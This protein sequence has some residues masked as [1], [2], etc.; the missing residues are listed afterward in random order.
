MELLTKSG[1][2]LMS[3]LLTLRD[4]QKTIFM[5]T[6]DIFRAKEYADRVG[7]LNNGELLTIIDKSE[8][9]EQDL[10]KTYL[11]FMK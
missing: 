5:S 8:L 9:K 6:H 10:E 11:N 4:K 1:T 2:E 3:L 7:I